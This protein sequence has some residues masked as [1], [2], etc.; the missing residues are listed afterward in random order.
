M[1]LFYNEQVASAVH[2]PQLD[3]LCSEILEEEQCEDMC[4]D[5]LGQWSRR[6]RID[7]ALNR[8]PADFYSKIWQVLTQVCVVS[9][10]CIIFV[11][12][13]PSMVRHTCHNA[14][15]IICIR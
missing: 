6:R 14:G 10:S 3:D 7:G 9:W 2:L 8:A 12:T 4:D 13:L 11:F 5:S 15:Q 1:I